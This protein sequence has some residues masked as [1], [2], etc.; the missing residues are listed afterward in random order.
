MTDL[1]SVDRVGP[2]RHRI[3]RHPYSITFSRPGRDRTRQTPA[4]HV[5]AFH[6]GS[7]FR[8]AASCRTSDASFD[9]A[10]GTGYFMYRKWLYQNLRLHL[11]A[12]SKRRQGPEKLELSGWLDW[13]SDRSEPTRLK[14]VTNGIKGMHFDIWISVGIATVKRRRVQGLSLIHI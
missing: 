5:S 2:T 7:S 13:S 4:R 10:P 8:R 9:R 3:S 14:T 12:S 11:G 1:P 6:D